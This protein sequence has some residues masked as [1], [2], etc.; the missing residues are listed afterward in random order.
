LRDKKLNSTRG[1]TETASL[2]QKNRPKTT[3]Q[4]GMQCPGK[5]EEKQEIGDRAAVPLEDGKSVLRRNGMA[6]RESS[7][8][9]KRGGSSHESFERAGRVMQS[10]E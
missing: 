8:Q 2:L 4:R 10:A 3:N 7:P 6:R 9:C 1:Q 5:K